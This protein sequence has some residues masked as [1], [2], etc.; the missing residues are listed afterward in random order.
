[1]SLILSILNPILAAPTVVREIHEARGDEMAIAE[2]VATMPR[3]WRQLD[4]EAASDMSTS[5]QAIPDMMAS[6]Q[7]P[8]SPVGS[9]SSG[10][11]DPHLSLDSSVSGYSLMLDRPPRLSPNLP[12]SLHE[13]ASPY[14][15]SSGSSEIAIPEWYYEIAPE[16]ILPPPPAWLEELP[17]PPHSINPEIPLSPLHTGSDRATTETYS[18]SDQFTPSHDPLSSTGWYSDESVNTPYSSASGGSLSSHYFSASNGLATSHNSISEASPSSTPLPP[19]ETPPDNAECFNKNVMKKLKII[20]GVTIV[21]GAIATIVGSQLR[22]R[23]F[24]DS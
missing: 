15:P 9:T 10:Y 4:S 18:L 5:Q 6:P 2:D 8:S 12:A 17:P 11:P 21:G 7:H 24:P 16:E 14:P 20:A 1:M 13:P 3:K 19:T 23:D 22:N